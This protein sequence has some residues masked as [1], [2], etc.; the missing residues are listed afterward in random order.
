MRTFN[1][2]GEISTPIATPSAT[3]QNEQL[4]CIIKAIRQER[5]EDVRTGSRTREQN[6]R[7]RTR[8]KSPKNKKKGEIAEE[9]TSRGKKKRRRKKKR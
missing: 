9:E 3:N 1:N 2:Y 7:G 8:R 4:Y 5:E 6:S